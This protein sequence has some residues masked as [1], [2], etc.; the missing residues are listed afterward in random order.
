MSLTGTGIQIGTATEFGAGI[1]FP[2]GLASD[3]TNVLMFDAAR[4]WDLNLETGVATQIGASG[5]GV[6]ANQIR[7]ATYHDGNFLFWDNATNNFYTFNRDTGVATSAA[8]FGSPPDFWAIAS[9]NNVLYAI[10]RADDY[11][12]SINLTASSETRIG[13]A[14][15]FGVSSGN[16]QALCVYDGGLIGISVSLGKILSI[17]ETNGTA[18]IIANANTLPDGGPEAAVEHDGLLYYLGSAADALFRLYDVKWDDTIADL[19]VDEGSDETWSLSDVSQ[20][21]ASF[22]LQGTPPS[23][24]TISGMDLTVTNA[25]DVSSDTDFEPQV[26]AIRDSKHEDKTLTVRV[27]D[28]TPPPP[29]NPPTFTAPAANY[30]V[31]ERANQ[32]IAATEFFTGHTRLAF[33]SGYTAPSWLMISGLNVVITGAPDVLEDTE[34]TVP[35]T[36]TNNDGSV[37]GSIMISVQQIDPAPVFGTPNRFDIDEG[38]SSVF[39]LSGDLQNTE[40]LAYQSGYSAPSWL[41]ISGLTLVITNAE[42]VSQDTDFDVLLAAEST[43]TAATA[44]RTVTIRV[45]DVAVPPP[46]PPLTDAVLDITVNPSSVTAGGIAT[47]TFT[48]DKVV[49]GFTDADASVSAGATKGTLR[50]EGNNAWTLPITAPS[51]GS[52]TVTVSV[53]ADVVSPG[54]NAD[55]VQFTYTAPPPPPPMLTT[56]GAPTSLSLSSTHNSITANWGA[57]SNTGGENPSRYDIR[58]DGGGWIDTGLDGTHTFDSLSP[59]TEYTVEVAAVNSE[60]RGTPASR[61]RRTDAAPIVV[62]VPGAPTSLSFTVT[63]NSIVAMWGVPADNGNEDPSRYD[64]RIDGGG[65]ID[66]GL[67][68]T[69]TFDSLS[70]NTEYTI[71]V[72]A[73]NSAGRGTPARGNPQRTEMPP[74][75]VPDA[76]TG[77]KVDLKPTTAVIR[78]AAVDGIDGYEVSYAEG[79]SPGTTW[80]PTGSTGTRFFVKRLKRGTQYTFGVR[81][82]NSAGAGAASRA[83]TQNTPIASLHNALFFKQCINYF[84]NGERVSEHGN[85]SNIIREVAD[86]DYQTFSNVTD[87]AIDMSRNNQPTRVDAVFIKSKGITQHS[88]TPT[89]G[90]GTGWTNEALPETVKNWE[91]TEVSTTVAGFQHHLYLLDSHFTATSVRVRFEGTNVE[92]YEIM[93]LEF[94]IS[95]DANG[96]F[97]E[98]ATNFVDREGVIHSDPGGGIAYDASIGDQRDKWEV[99]YVVR[100]VPGKTM[101]ETPEDFLYW[102]A[103]NRNHVFCMEPSRF[104]W[105][106]FPAVFVGKSVPVRYRTDDKTGGEILNFRVAEQ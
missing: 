81:G 80:I 48:F 103:K 65:W 15:E 64:I 101:L 91:G 73:V 1:R 46:P 102:R 87:Y 71:N 62:T 56:P 6:G 55:S 28:T 23:W 96:D 99:D 106:I 72:A 37:N 5:L 76:P 9:L 29:L 60:G 18:D 69:H 14:D 83:V 40:S 58:I 33:R 86:N 82:R 35:L 92:L 21:A 10:D 89:G 30:E 20:D 38:S 98:I 44:D 57:P 16:I 51:A 74:V 59:E 78:W 61:T 77:L 43:K 75:I 67:D 88:G 104:P 42:Q 95:I 36:A 11:L 84:D 52:G 8:G 97:T 25:P 70:P 41:T 19:E 7:A 22:A 17:D 31:N 85:P 68:G 12:V 32:T 50:A 24:L 49:T 47:V 34:F 66:T 100:V 93:L 105:R 45:R 53:G 3:G 27:R 79:A 4:A 2:R 90:S 54:N 26:R 94:G 13:T 39:D 63:H